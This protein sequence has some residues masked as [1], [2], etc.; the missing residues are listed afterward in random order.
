MHICAILEKQ[1]HS[2]MIILEKQLHSFMNSSTTLPHTNSHAV[3]RE[4]FLFSVTTVEVTLF[5][6]QMRGHSQNFCSKFLF[7]DGENPLLLCHQNACRVDIL[8]VEEEVVQMWAIVDK[9]HLKTKSLC[10]PGFSL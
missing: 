3:E 5:V 1:L 7:L 6:D 4:G 9:I 10:E 8:A 2:F